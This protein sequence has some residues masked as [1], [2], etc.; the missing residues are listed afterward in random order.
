[1]NLFDGMDRDRSDYD[2]QAWK[3]EERKRRIARNESFHREANERLRESARRFRRANERMQ[4]M[5]ECGDRLCAEMVLLSG[6]EYARVRERGDRFVIAP[7]HEI[8]D[9]E[10]VVLSEPHYS[11]V[12]KVGLGR[13]VALVENEH[14]P[15]GTDDPGSAA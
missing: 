10:F 8:P 9:V 15:R 6:S 12:E 5:C 14:R 4:Y 2:L 3:A 11:I 13:L 1:M 7:D